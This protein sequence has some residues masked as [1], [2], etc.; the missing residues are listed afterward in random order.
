MTLAYNGTGYHGWQIQADDPDTIQGRIE[1]ALGWLLGEPTAVTGAGRTDAGVHASYYVAHFDALRPDLAQDPTVVPRLN[2]MLPGQIV[3]HRLFRMHDNAHA[4]FD[5]VA[6]TYQY[7]IARCKQPFGNDAWYPYFYPL[8]TEDM[9][10]ACD[11][12]RTYTDFTSFSKLHT[13]VKTNICHI[14]QARFFSQTDGPYHHLIFEITADRFL[15]NMVRAIVGTLLEIGRGRWTLD[16]LQRIIEA[17]DRCRAG[18]SVPATGLF[19]TDIRYPYPLLSQ[20]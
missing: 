6:R 3:I 13:D 18:M 7:R 16:D 20:E 2:R 12:L 10:A 19:L 11:I 14:T 15:R 8:A 1:Q 17:K 9:Q 5:A 4:R